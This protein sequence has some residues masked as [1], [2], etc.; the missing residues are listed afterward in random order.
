MTKTIIPSLGLYGKPAADEL[1]A[2]AHIESMG[3]RGGKLGWHIK[4]HRH[5]HLYQILCVYDGE[6][7]VWIDDFHRQLKGSWM[8]TVPLGSVHSFLFRPDSEGVVLSIAAPLLTDEALFARRENLTELINAPQVVD[9]CSAGA[10]LTQLRRYMA[11]MHDELEQSTEPGNRSVVLLLQLILIAL[12]RQLSSDGD[13]HSTRQ[14]D[15]KRLRQF[16]ALVDRHFR[17][18]W[19]LEQYAGELNVSVSTLK[20]L[21][22][23]TLSTNPKAIVQGRLI[24]EAKRRLIYTQQPLDELAYTLGFKDPAYFSRSFKRALGI[25]PSR[26]RERNSFTHRQD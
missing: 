12:K 5:S 25:S 4:P 19:T 23:E 20:R 2:L 6:L 17:D 18:H 16:R 24:N 9:F 7:E 8:V 13:A 3:E 10:R 1:P 26:Y 14:L 21:C 22:L 11:A 15:E